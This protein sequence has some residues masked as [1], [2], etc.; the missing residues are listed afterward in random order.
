MGYAS[1][2]DIAAGIVAK[3]E[4]TGKFRQ[5]L[6]TQATNGAQIWAKIES[7]VGLPGAVVALGGCEYADRGL[8]RTLMPMIFVVSAFNR[9]IEKEAAGIWDLK[10]DVEAAFYPDEE[11][12]DG[13]FTTVSEIE[14]HLL[15]SVPIESPE[16]VCAYCLTLSGTEFMQEKPIEET[17]EETTEEE[18]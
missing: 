10:E 9:G 5:V 17:I 16:K 7:L 2:K 6:Y 4:A 1:F 11:G 14:F 13:I 15:E 3:V 12:S 8:R 18:N